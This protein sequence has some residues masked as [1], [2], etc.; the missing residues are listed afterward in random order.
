MG[1]HDLG[2]TST[3]SE[4]EILGNC[5]YPETS[6]RS[7]GEILGDPRRAPEA[8]RNYLL[9]ILFFFSFVEQMGGRGRGGGVWRAAGKGDHPPPSPIST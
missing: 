9:T 3:R 6:T 7:E 8:R 4:E 1:I 5:Q 2:E